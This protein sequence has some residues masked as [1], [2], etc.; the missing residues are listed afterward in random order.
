MEKVN[1]DENF[2]IKFIIKYLKYRWM[3]YKIEN[4]DEKLFYFFL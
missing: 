4:F 3:I 2:L 1:Y